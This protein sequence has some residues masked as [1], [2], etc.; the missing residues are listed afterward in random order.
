MPGNGLVVPAHGSAK[1]FC[2]VAVDRD[3]RAERRLVGLVVHGDRVRHVEEDAV[4]AAN[5]SS[6]VAE[7]V[8][9]EAEP[10]AE[11]AQRDVEAAL[12]NARVAR[13]TRRRREH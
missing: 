5:G 6:A 11:V 10:R 13:E 2:S 3:L 12:R 7:D 4:A 8:P 1:L 9:R